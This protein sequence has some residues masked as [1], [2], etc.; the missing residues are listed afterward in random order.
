MLEKVIRWRIGKSLAESTRDASPGVNDSNEK[1]LDEGQ[2][3]YLKKI[4]DINVQMGGEV[5]GFHVNGEEIRGIETVGWGSEAKVEV[6]KERGVVKKTAERVM[7]KYDEQFAQYY[8]NN[9]EKQFSE[10]NEKEKVRDYMEGK[11]D[12]R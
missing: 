1:K 5:R 10:I 2:M 7:S 8:L 3:N 9:L 6:D 12:P 4:A 11:I